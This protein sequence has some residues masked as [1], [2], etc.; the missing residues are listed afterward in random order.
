[1]RSTHPATPRETPFGTGSASQAFNEFFQ[2]WFS[3][4]DAQAQTMSSVGDATQQCAVIYDHVDRQ[5]AASIPAMAIAAPPT[6]PKPPP[7]NQFFPQAQ[8]PMA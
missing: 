2:A 1:M 3:A 5:I 4:L 7:A 6:P 8:P